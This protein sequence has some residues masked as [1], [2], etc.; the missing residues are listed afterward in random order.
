MLDAPRAP[1]RIAHRGMPL[2]VRENTLAGFALAIDSGAQ[3]IELDVHATRD[4][5]VIVHHD[6]ALPNDRPIASLA[7]ADLATAN[8]PY[9][10]PTLSDVCHLVDGRVELFV[11]I[12]GA[13][14][15]LLVLSTLAGYR[16]PRAI[17]SF[18][19]AMIRRIAGSGSSSR[20]GVLIEDASADVRSI[21]R[22]TGAL[23]VWPHHS[24]VSDA[25]IDAA[26]EGGGRVIPWTVNDPSL[27]RR[28]TAMRVD[29]ICSDDVSTL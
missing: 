11:E 2:A 14:I 10:I 26:H 19:H 21:M 20:L 22:D 5:V 28:F 12:K 17:H 9:A 23:D 16:G 25:L 13:D 6:A 7:Y 24:I 27:A 1:L 15:E 3:G 29:G 8:L 4:N 18:D